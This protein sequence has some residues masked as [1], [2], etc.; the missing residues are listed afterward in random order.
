M[1]NTPDIIKTFIEQL[2][3]SLTIESYSNDSTNTTII[4]DNP[5]YARSKLILTVDAA[6][7]EVISVT[8]NSIVVPGILTP[9]VVILQPMFYYNES[10]IDFNNLL[11]TIA[12]SRGKMPFVLLRDPIIETYN[13]KPTSAID[14]TAE[15]NLLIL[16]DSDFT[17][18]TEGEDFYNNVINRIR[19]FVKLILDSAKLYPVFGNIDTYRIRDYKKFGEYV[20]SKGTVSYFFDENLSGVQLTITLPI[21]KNLNCN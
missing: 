6:P 1:N 20:Q 21:L 8:D 7:L 14:Y 4:V 19:S 10:Y 18:Y 15:V 2:D 9:V 5:L 11:G 12:S 16:D 3:L 13:N 17:R